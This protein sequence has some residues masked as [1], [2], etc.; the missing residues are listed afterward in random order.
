MTLSLAWLSGT[1]PESVPVLSSRIRIARNL[2]D[3]PFPY[4]SDMNT[5]KEIL[6]K[7]AEAANQE[8]GLKDLKLIELEKISSPDRQTFVENYQTSPFHLQ[9]TQGAGLL[10]SADG[11]ISIMINE[12]DHVRAQCFVSGL[13]LENCWEKINTVD[14]QLEKRLSYAFNE[15]WGYLEACPSNLGTGLRAS[16]LLHLPALTLFQA[17]P[18]LVQS[19]NQSGFVAR[20]FYGEGSESQGHFYQISNALSLG[21]TEE[22]I[23]SRMSSA[24]KQVIGQEMQFRERLKRE[25]FNFLNDRA[26]RALGILK[27]AR[28]INS[29]EAIEHLSM[30]RLGVSL[31]ILP[32]IP[33]SLLN[34]LLLMTRPGNLQKA[35]GIEA[36]PVKRDLMRADYLRNALR[37]TPG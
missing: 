31:Q 30:V 25:Q 34:E 3:Y 5:R 37:D 18:S 7:V 21:P 14:D 17:I 28:I 11:A 27:S 36:D 13:D 16:V 35:F 6:I 19:L 12:E 4:R 26:W 1:G 23:V 2:K 8:P 20:G 10:Q 15:N 22:D 24:A 33:M 29:I 9:N 32:N